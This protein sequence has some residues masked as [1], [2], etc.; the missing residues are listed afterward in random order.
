MRVHCPLRHLFNAF[1][2][3]HPWCPTNSPEATEPKTH[4]GLNNLPGDTGLPFRAVSLKDSAH[5]LPRRTLLLLA[6]TN[7]AVLSRK[8]Q[9]KSVLSWLC[10][11][12]N[13]TNLV[14]WK[15]G[16]CCGQRIV[17]LTCSRLSELLML[18]SILTVYC[19]LYLRKLIIS[20]LIVW[21]TLKTFFFYIQERIKSQLI[22][23][24]KP[25]KSALRFQ[26]D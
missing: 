5:D 8:E 6:I 18:H 21:I 4:T 11:L 26:M 12:T 17:V 25:N 3:F 20:T 13:G 22:S 7:G 9:P 14:W 2:N 24:S 15:Y 1:P 23:R 19:I 10:S 16:C